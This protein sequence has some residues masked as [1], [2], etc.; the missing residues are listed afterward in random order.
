MPANE[1]YDK[2]AD[3]VGL[4]KETK[5]RFVTYMRFRWKSQELSHVRF[6]Y[7]KE[8]AHRFML[9]REYECSDRSGRIVL[10]NVVDYEAPLIKNY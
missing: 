2:V 4:S 8:W 5:R 6:G 9:G 10:N 3:Q 1:T 7:A